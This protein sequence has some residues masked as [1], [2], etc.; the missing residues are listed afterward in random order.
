LTATIPSEER[1]VSGGHGDSNLPGSEIQREPLEDFEIDIATD[2]E[3]G[4]VDPSAFEASISERYAGGHLSVHV[5]FRIVSGSGYVDPR[6]F[7]VVFHRAE[8]QRV[9]REARSDV[10]E[11]KKVA[12]LHGI[13]LKDGD[14]CIEKPVFVLVREDIESPERMRTIVIPSLVWLQILDGVDVILS[15]PG[16][17][18]VELGNRIRVP[19]RVNREGRERSPFVRFVSSELD[20]FAGQVIDGGSEVVDALSDQKSAPLGR[21]FKDDE[22]K[23]IVACIRLELSPD[24]VR[25]ASEVPLKFRFD[26]IR[27][28][29]RP[30]QLETY[31][32]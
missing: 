15:H 9:V 1:A 22:T 20:Q 31:S 19:R 5:H 24:G 4:A 16:D 32:I 27:V 11:R 21:L 13:R 8:R 17:Q 10:L 30:R 14:C 7:A 3:E 23:D 6:N 12:D 25:V 2:V 26:S 29:L 28:F 18:A